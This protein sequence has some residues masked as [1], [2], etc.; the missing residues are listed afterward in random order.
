MSTFKLTCLCLT[1]P[2]HGQFSVVLQKAKDIRGVHIPGDLYSPKDSYQYLTVY[3]QK[4]FSFNLN[5][6][7]FFFLQCSEIKAYSQGFI[8]NHGTTDVV[9]MK[10]LFSCLFIMLIYTKCLNLRKQILISSTHTN[11]PISKY[12]S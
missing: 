3:T 11:F 8:L 4:Y 7:S 1:V 9:S 2:I 12:K 6:R 10:Y 5:R